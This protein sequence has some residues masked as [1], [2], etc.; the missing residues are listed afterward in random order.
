LLGIFVCRSV[1]LSIFRTII[2]FIGSRY[3]GSWQQRALIA[4]RGVWGDAARVLLRSHQQS[5]SIT[6]S[7]IQ[8]PGTSN[9]I[10]RH[11]SSLILA[12]QFASTLNL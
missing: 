8:Y 2:E 10:L 7:H 4:A 1:A 3:E 6:H 9:F 5:T 11:L 12:V